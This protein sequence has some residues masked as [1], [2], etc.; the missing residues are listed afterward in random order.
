M[1]DKIDGLGGVR[2]TQPMKRAG[3]SGGSSAA[4]FANQLDEGEE[5]SAT[6]SLASAN[7][8]SG[9]LGV[10]EVDD[11][12]AHASRGKMRAEE[13]LNRLEDLRM[14]LLSG[15]ISRERLMQ[16]TRIVGA[17]KAQIKDP[18]LAEILDEIDLRAQVEL[19]KYAPM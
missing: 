14:E 3:K 8:I 1:I 17:R 15:G 18:R 6:G 10:Q 5:T 19:A 9:I 12:L 16:L 11:A 13:I 7:A 4:S 2:T